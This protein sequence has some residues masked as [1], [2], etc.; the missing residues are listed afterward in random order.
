MQQSQTSGV[1]I[2]CR[3]TPEPD[4][5]VAIYDTNQRHRHHMQYRLWTSSGVVGAVCSRGRNAMSS[6][7]PEPA[8][9]GNMWGTGPGPVGGEGLCMQ[10]GVITEQLGQVL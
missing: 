6:T 5:V 2:V 3:M 9:M 8:R 1:H 10:C 7:D 4:E